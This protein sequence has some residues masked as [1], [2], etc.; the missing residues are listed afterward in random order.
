LR[1][2]PIAW[3]V[4]WVRIQTILKL[5]PVVPGPVGVAIIVL[6]LLVIAVEAVRLL[7]DSRGFG[8]AV[9]RRPD[10]PCAAYGYEPTR[11]AAMEAFARSWRRQ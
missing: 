9:L 7:L 8:P 6:A 2:S 10:M 11:E 1:F 5:L 3:V 4:Q